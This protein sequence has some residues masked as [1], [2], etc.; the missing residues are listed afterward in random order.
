MSR[1]KKYKR[2]EY[3]PGFWVEYETAKGFNKVCRDTEKTRADLFR[4]YMEAICATGA[5]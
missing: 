5:R 1:P 4:R 2:K 3:I